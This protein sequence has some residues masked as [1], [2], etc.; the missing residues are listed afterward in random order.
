MK[1]IAIKERAA[2]NEYAGS[3]WFETKTFDGESRLKD[4]IKW[5]G[6]HPIRQSGGRLYLTLPQDHENVKE[7]ELEG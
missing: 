7:F 2:G 6:E 5:A 4:I 3:V 1:I